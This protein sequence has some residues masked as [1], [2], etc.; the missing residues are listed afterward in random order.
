MASAVALV[1]ARAPVVMAP[2]RIRWVPID[3][4][5]ARWRIG[6]VWGGAEVA[7][8]LEAF[9]EVTRELAAGGW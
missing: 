3:H 9:L 5:A 7:P 4:E 8:A 1:S 2:E 6:L